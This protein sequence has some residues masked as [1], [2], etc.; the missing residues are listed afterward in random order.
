[1]NLVNKLL[2]AC[3]LFTIPVAASQRSEVIVAMTNIKK[4]VMQDQD[5]QG[6]FTQ[7]E[8]PEEFLEK[9]KRVALL[10]RFRHITKGLQD[11]LN[12]ALEALLAPPDLTRRS[13]VFSAPNQTQDYA[14]ITQAVQS[15][16]LR[17]L[18]D[19]VARLRA[20]EKERVD[21]ELANFATKLEQTKKDCVNFSNIVSETKERA[22]GFKHELWQFGSDIAH[23]RTAP[24]IQ[25][26]VENMRS[27]FA[28]QITN[29][30]RCCVEMTEKNEQLKA[31]SDSLTWVLKKQAGNLADAQDKAHEAWVGMNK[32]NRL[33]EEMQQLAV[34]ISDIKMLAIQTKF[35]LERRCDAAKA[36]TRKKKAD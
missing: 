4:L 6:F 15:D 12:P 14:P 19:E 17:S 23:M 9:A 22:V 35:D 24:A 30:E 2:I 27:F 13:N 26:Q 32:I 7:G 3:T 20:Q 1:M 36:K 34:Q 25:S 29:L 21:A 10:T 31:S 33:T 28:Q 16:E 5:L 18:R 8:S 11:E